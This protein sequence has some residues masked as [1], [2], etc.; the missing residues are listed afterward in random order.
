MSDRARAALAALAAWMIG[1]G[2]ATAGPSVA[3]LDLPFAATALR[4]PGSETAL[5]IAT[6][7]LVPGTRRKPASADP[8]IGPEAE[9]PEPL[10]VVWGEG[11]GAVLTLR[12]GQIR[13]SPIDAEAVEGLTVAETPRN[14]VPGARRVLDGPLTAYLTG[15]T[16]ALGG[17]PGQAA[18]LT[19]RE[20][21]PIGMTRDPK[22]V[23]TATET[24]APGAEAVFAARTPL[25]ARLAGKPVLLA[26]AALGGGASAA[27]LIGKD[28]PG[29]WA[30]LART[31]PQAG[32]GPEGAPLAFAAAGD[33]TGK[34][35]TQLAAV[36]APDGAGMLQLWEIAPEG[37]RLLHEAPGYTAA[38]G[39]A[40]LAAAV[41]TGSVPL[42]ALPSADRSALALVSLK[43][44]VSERARI[45]L[46]APAATGLASLGRGDAAR[47]LVGLADG[48][49]AVVDPG[50]AGAAR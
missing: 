46:P 14:A 48:R 13:V 49:V 45:P 7:G 19:I 16:R 26:V 27:L 10:A 36:R 50:L 41:E 21:Q 43:D 6:S 18:G 47:L 4:G 12:E 34:G 30:V 33:F 25:V 28:G 9:G 5:S 15:P 3:I 20:R 40:P 11:G 24:V 39:E 8:K 44:G 32:A 38:R 23:P 29:H 31:P 22:P 17:G 35:R 1:A 37:F 2:A 42:L